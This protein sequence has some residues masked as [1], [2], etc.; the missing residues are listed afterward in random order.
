[1]PASP[2][3]G[4]RG[5]RRMGSSQGLGLMQVLGRNGEDGGGSPGEMGAAV[6]TV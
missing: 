2:N 6:R 3:P 4:H 5:L 1:M